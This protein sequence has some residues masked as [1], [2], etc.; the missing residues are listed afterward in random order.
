MFVIL[1]EANGSLKYIISLLAYVL[2]CL[3]AFCLS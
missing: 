2:L 1:L 3:C